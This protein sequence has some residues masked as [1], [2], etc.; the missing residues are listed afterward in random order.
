MSQFN[1]YLKPG[2]GRKRK[3][4]FF[5]GAIVLGILALYQVWIFGYNAG[6]ED[7]VSELKKL[8]Q[9]NIDKIKSSPEVR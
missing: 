1:S 9:N 7:T 6:I 8:I 3:L 4:V 5:V 2:R